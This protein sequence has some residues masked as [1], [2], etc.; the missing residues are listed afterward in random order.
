MKRLLN[1]KQ[2]SWKMKLAAAVS[3]LW[4]L[5]WIITGLREHALFWGLVFG[6]FPIFVVW[7]A[8]MI[9]AGPRKSQE[10]AL[11]ENIVAGQQVQIQERRAYKRLGYPPDRRPTLKFGPHELEIL[12]ISERGLKLSNPDKLSFDQVTDGRT[13]MLSGKQITVNGK[14]AWSLNREVGMVMDPIPKAI[15]DEE[16]DF[17]PG[18]KS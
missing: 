7:G 8:W 9:A 5:F 16:K 3:A 14:V 1:F 10:A 13:V 4:L 11:A 15:I 17:L 6:V 12:N 2:W 18:E